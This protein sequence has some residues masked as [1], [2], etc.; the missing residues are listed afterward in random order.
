MLRLAQ[1]LTID[2]CYGVGALD[3]ARGASSAAGGPGQGSAASAKASSGWSDCE[4]PAA[5]EL[6]ALIQGRGQSPSFS[7]HAIL[8]RSLKGKPVNRVE[9][10]A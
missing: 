10:K 4:R 1:L 3:S 8:G 5:V 7:L 2:P 6:L 9:A